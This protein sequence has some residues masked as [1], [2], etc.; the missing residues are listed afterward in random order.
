[1]ETRKNDSVELYKQKRKITL[2]DQW[3]IYKNRICPKCRFPMNANISKKV[4]LGRS[5]F[6]ENC[7]SLFKR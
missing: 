7:Q 5:F 4:R 3:L 6:C 1:M 2:Q